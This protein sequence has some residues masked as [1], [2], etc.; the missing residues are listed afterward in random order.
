MNK[1]KVLKQLLSTKDKEERARIAFQL[2]LKRMSDEEIEQKIEKLDNLI[3]ASL[4]NQEELSDDDKKWLEIHELEKSGQI[5]EMEAY[6][7]YKS[8]LKR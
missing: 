4:S 5:N 8:F 1:R 3:L 6:H 7:R 2:R